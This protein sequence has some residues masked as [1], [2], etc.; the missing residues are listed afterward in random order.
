MGFQI[1]FIMPL[2]FFC[3]FIDSSLG[4]GYGT[5]LT[6]LLLL[7]GFEPLQIVPAVLLSEFVTGIM[8]GFFHHRVR[9]VDFRLSSQDTKVAFALSVFAIVGTTVSVFLALRL[10]P[11]VLKICIGTIVVS[12]GIYLLL[13]RNRTLKFSWKRIVA[14][15]ALASFNKGMSGGGYGPLVTGGQ[16]LSGIGVKNAVGITSVSEGVT[17]LIGV[18]LYAIFKTD[19]D[20]ALAPW[21]MTGAVLS[22]PFA[23][24]TLKRVREKKARLAIASAAILLGCLTLSRALLHG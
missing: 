2:A 18:I 14:V 19:I 5:A 23:T 13:N 24:H 11:Q 17:C 16:M 9:N 15:G 12:M 10:P 1:F 4:M 21:L 8:A 7:M 22:V 20:W 6:P 3:E